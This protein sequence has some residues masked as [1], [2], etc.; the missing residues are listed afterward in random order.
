MESFIPAQDGLL[1]RSAT[2]SLPVQ[3]EGSHW[4]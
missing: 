4:Q 2:T 3:Q 1:Q